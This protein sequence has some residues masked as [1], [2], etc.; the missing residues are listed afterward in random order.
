MKS[1]LIGTLAAVLAAGAQS[2]EAERQLKAAMNAELV[3]GDLKTAIKQ[4]G[5][6]A[7]KYKN[8]RGV[9]AMALVK[10]AEAYQKLGDAESRKIF[11]RVVSEYGDQKEAV[12]LARARLGGNASPGRPT[13]T[14]IGSGPKA[15]FLSQSRGK[16]SAD[17]R[18]LSFT[19]WDTGDLALYEISAGTDRR[20]TTDANHGKGVFAD[21]SVVSRDGKLIAYNWRDGDKDELRI[22][23][24][25]GDPSPRRLHQ[26]SEISWYWPW[27]WSPDGR[28]LA[29]RVLRKDATAQI[30]LVNVADGSLRILKRHLLFAR[31]QISWL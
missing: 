8:E 17:G 4:Y 3:N 21:D 26:N 22:A 13:T 28:W 24:V 18:Y 11:E 10:K 12:T 16:V 19:D 31:W 23:N 5:E 29:V 20:L 9:A 2:N 25:A 7:G 6:I 27:D 14:L 15:P 30:G 1:I